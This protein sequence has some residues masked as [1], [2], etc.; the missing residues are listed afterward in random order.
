MPIRIDEIDC[1]DVLT[2]YVYVYIDIDVCRLRLRCV[3]KCNV[4]Q[5]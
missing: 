3:L 4:S 5:P 1:S 2:V